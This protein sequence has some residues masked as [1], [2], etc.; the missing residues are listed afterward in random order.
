MY[1]SHNHRTV[2]AL[3]STAMVAGIGAM[4]V[5]AR[6]WRVVSATT[7]LVGLVKSSQ[8]SGVVLSALSGAQG[9]YD[10]QTGRM[11]RR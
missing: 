1:A 8:L 2:S 7:V 9:W 4:L 11:T 3:A 10:E 5:F 6:P